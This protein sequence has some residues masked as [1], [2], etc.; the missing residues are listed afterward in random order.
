MRTA[1]AIVV[2][3]L[4]AAAFLMASRRNQIDD[5]DPTGGE[6]F[7]RELHAELATIDRVVVLEH[8]FETDFPIGDESDGSDADD[9]DANEASEV[10]VTPPQRIY[11][12]VELASSARESLFD[13]L[14]NLSVAAPTIFAACIFSPHHTIQL[15]SGPSLKSELQVCYECTDAEWSKATSVAPVGLVSALTPT[16][17]AAGMETDRDWQALA[18]SPL[19]SEVK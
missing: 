13:A 18:A 15:Y 8:S 6:Q 16:I 3:V 12:K 5:V 4:I 2:T 10:R 17:L 7:K 9:L 1:L 11:R 19:E 14:R